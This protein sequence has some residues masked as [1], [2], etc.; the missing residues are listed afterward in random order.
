MPVP[1]LG[2]D[3]RSRRNPPLG[4]SAGTDCDKKLKVES[5]F[6][7]IALWNRKTRAA[8]FRTKH[9]VLAAANQVG[10]RLLSR[11][12]A[13]QRKMARS[14]NTCAEHASS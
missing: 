14:G 9:A 1:S 11:A 12:H 2:V 8:G 5:R 7:A 10:L 3:D 6:R 4:L 13:E